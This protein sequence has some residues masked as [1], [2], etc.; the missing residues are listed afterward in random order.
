MEDKRFSWRAAKILPRRAALATRKRRC[1]HSGLRR[2]PCP[3]AP[4]TSLHRRSG[5]PLTCCL[6]ETQ[7]LQRVLARRTGSTAT[8][9]VTDGDARGGAFS[10]LAQG[11]AF[12][13]TSLG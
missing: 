4:P 13:S 2:L 8:H 11:G 1:S 3:V 5:G 12:S 6:G 9:G 7:L 10:K